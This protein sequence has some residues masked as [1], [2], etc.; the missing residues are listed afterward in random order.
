MAE[1]KTADE[2]AHIEHELAILRDRLARFVYWGGVLKIVVPTGG[3]VAAAVLC[4][5]SLSSLNGN[6]AL[7]I[8]GLIMALATAILVRL[9]FRGWTMRNWVD[10]AS[11]QNGWNGRYASEAEAIEDMIAE[12]V[13]RLAVLRGIS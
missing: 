12:R 13:E 9:S 6:S 1:P 11:Q 8:F 10:M 4:A 2:I 7:A 3:Y 5:G